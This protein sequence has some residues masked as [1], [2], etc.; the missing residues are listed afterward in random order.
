MTDPSPHPRATLENGD[1]PDPRVDAD[2]RARE[3]DHPDPRALPRQGCEPRRHGR[4]RRA[5]CTS[6]SSPAS[7]TAP[8]RSSR[9]SRT[10][11]TTRR[12]SWRRR[13]PSIPCAPTT[14]CRSTGT[15]HIAYIPNDT[16]VGLSKLPRLLEFYA[17]RPQL[18]ERL[19]EQ[20]AA[21]LEEELKPQGVM[22][23]DRGPAPL[24]GDARRQEAGRRDGDVRDPGDL[25]AEGR[26]GGVSGPHAAAGAEEPFS[27]SGVSFP[28][29][30]I[31]MSRSRRPSPP[32]SPPLAFSL[33]A[34]AER[35]RHDRQ[36]RRDGCSGVHVHFGDR[37][38]ARGEE[39]ITICRGGTRRASSLEGSRNGGVT[40][41]APT[42]ASSR[43]RRALAAAGDDEASARAVLSKIALRTSGGRV[44]LEGPDGET[45]ERLPDRVGPRRTPTS[46]SRARTA[47]SPCS[48]LPERS[49]VKAPRTAPSR[50]RA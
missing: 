10:K 42:W 49:R 29:R 32:S 22:V 23:V 9:R 17:R 5:G 40:S 13:S 36:G 47:R 35:D 46:R 15:A 33:P 34:A 21:V 50:S 25:P 37:L 18:Q 31:S 1:P 28:D 7:T 16:I 30:R 6:R 41:A 4:A 24:R 45:V 26:P 43:S 39:T 48:D 12:W 8:G 44:T 19:T 2:R 27:R 3:G 38:T 14:S 11:S 20:V